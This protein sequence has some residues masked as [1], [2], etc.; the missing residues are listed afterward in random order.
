[1]ITEVEKKAWNAFVAMVKGFLG[2]T[3]A[4]NHKDTVETFLDSF[5]A[6]GCSVSI[7]VPF[8]KGHLNEY[9]AN[10]G[11]MSDEHRIRFHQ[12]IKVMEERY[13]GQW[14]THDGRLLLEHSKRLC[15]YETLQTLS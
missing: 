9:P 4:A 6:V 7:N 5:H 8:L 11:D 13:Q 10:L 3:K 2:N 14:N 12:D 1:M 15:R